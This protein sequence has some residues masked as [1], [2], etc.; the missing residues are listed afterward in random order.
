[1]K[2]FGVHIYFT[3]MKSDAEEAEGTEE[4]PNLT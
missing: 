4:Y 2:G 3:S 1:M